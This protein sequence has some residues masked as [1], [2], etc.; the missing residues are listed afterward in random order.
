MSSQ[1][2]HELR[3]IALRHKL[4]ALQLQIDDLQRELQ[5]AR[6]AM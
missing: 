2:P 6:S 5:T 4:D 1:L 3:L